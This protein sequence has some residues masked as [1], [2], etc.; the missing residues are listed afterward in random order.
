MTAA[1]EERLVV[2]LEARIRDFER[3][4]QR[5]R[6]AANDNLGAIEKRAEATRDRLK[7]TFASLGTGLAG[8]A[9][10]GGLGLAGLFAGAK[11]A[12]A[13]IAQIA[14]EAQKAGVAVEAFQEL[15]YAAQG[16]MVG[17]DALTDGLKEMQLR[18][19][20]FIVTGAG[21]GAEAFQR[22][23]YGAEELSDKLQDPSA[24]FEEI[25]GKL[26][27]LDKASQIRIA[28]E[29][30]G[31][32]GGEQFV[33]LVEQ[34]NDYI[35]R[36][37]QEARDTGNVLDAELVKRAIEIDRQF[38][39]LASTV[40]T[41]LKG[42]LV[43]VVALMRDFADMLNA[44]EKQSSA[45]LQRRIDLLTASAEN[46]RKSS[47]AF[48]LGGGEAGIKRRE[49]EAAALQAQLDGR[50]PRVTI[51]PTGGRGDLSN[52]ETAATRQ[53]D[54]LAKSYDGIVLASERRIAQMATEQ[55]A[56]G[57]TTA[58]AETLRVKQDLL[59]EVQR[60]GI[61]L[62][63]EQAAQLD[64]LASRSGQA[65]G[66]L[67]EAATANAKLAETMDTVRFTAADVVS[68]F[69]QDL[70]NGVSAADALNNA[71]G[72]VLDTLLEVAIQQAVT[73]LFG[74]PGTTGGGALGSLFT[75]APVK[76]ATGG[77]I[78]GPGTGTSDSV[79]AMLSNGEY[80]VRAKQ[81]ARFGPLLEAINSGQVRQ[82]AAGGFVAPSLAPAANDNRGASAPVVNVTVHNAPAGTQAQ[83]QVSAGGN[84]QIDIEVI[85]DQIEGRMA[86]NVTTRRGSLGRALEA[87]YGLNAMRGR[88]R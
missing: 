27:E 22:L 24:L 82:L 17:V 21:G 15:G 67:E 20:E 36:M 55:Q 40:G 77:R 19:D 87:S 58:A 57:M 60:A 88:S 9:G 10:L 32:T 33:R 83:A 14:A 48:A 7:S 18:A 78:S 56:L 25:V 26:G 5:G 53:A 76:A 68:G 85:L 1:A 3:N 37:R 4:M 62:T 43:G 59:A 39:R 42:A 61:A 63:S 31:G 79:P 41:N 70:R 49:A 12:A 46:M 47:L 23:G 65:A 80:V 69:V 74:A 38:A 64:D 52:V 51:N 44:T 54:Q 11:T 2:A 45:T 73:G 35:A 81:A 75:A 71:L 72:R 28:D 30:F 8:A 84:G 34:G 29:L 16:A 6:K 86:E 50:P 13:D 66:A